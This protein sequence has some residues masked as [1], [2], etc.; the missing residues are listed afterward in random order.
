MQQS[1]SQDTA[2]LFVGL[3]S[4]IKGFLNASD[5]K[6]VVVSIRSRN[7]GVMLD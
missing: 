6:I 3:R 1:V 7:F 2:G 4:S 5:L